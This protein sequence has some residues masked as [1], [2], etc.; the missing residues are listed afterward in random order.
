MKRR[1]LIITIVFGFVLLGTVPVAATD[2]DPV[3]ITP[4]LDDVAKGGV[5]PNGEVDEERLCDL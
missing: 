2:K 4:T 5:Q 1:A 3:G